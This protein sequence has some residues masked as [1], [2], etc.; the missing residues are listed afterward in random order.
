MKNQEVF[1]IITG[2]GLNVEQL[3]TNLR[4]GFQ[5]LEQL[6]QQRLCQICRGFAVL[7]FCCKATF[8]QVINR[9]KRMVRIP[10]FNLAI[11]HHLQHIDCVSKILPAGGQCIHQD[12]GVEY[13]L[14]VSLLL[15]INGQN[16][17]P[18][19]HLEPSDSHPRCLHRV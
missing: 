10:A 11:A 3:V 9:G 2:H 12:I 18:P 16:N 17:V 7:R 4:Q 1:Q 15:C 13:K 19:V 14:Y 5:K 6:A 8:Q